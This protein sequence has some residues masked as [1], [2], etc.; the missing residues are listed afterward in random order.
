[1]SLMSK[2]L[3]LEIA[4]E[5]APLLLYPN[6]GILTTAALFFATLAESINTG[7][8][9]CFCLSV[10]RTTSGV[11]EN[12]APFLYLFIWNPVTI[13]IRRAMFYVET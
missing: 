3:A 5:A 1:M 7:M 13:F 12:M 4:H 9:F 10:R 2:Y 8:R 11:A 6:P